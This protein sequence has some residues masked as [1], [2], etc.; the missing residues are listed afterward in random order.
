[1][2]DIAARADDAAK[3]AISAIRARLQV[4][5]KTETEVNDGYASL[6]ALAMF[7][8]TLDACFST[9]RAQARKHD[10]AV[11]AKARADLEE[12]IL[13]KAIADGRVVLA[14]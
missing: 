6:I 9:V 12:S 2:S 13:R 3:T 11:T 14:S 10:D 8:P 5:G 7:D 1:V 4:K